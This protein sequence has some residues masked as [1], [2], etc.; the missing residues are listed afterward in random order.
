MGRFLRDISIDN[1]ILF[2]SENMIFSNVSYDITDD[3]SSMIYKLQKVN[4][5]KEIETEKDRECEY[6]L[7][8]KK[9][10]YSR[11]HSTDWRS[12][13]HIEYKN[14]ILDEYSKYINGSKYED[15]IHK[16]K[17]EINFIYQ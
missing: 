1:F 4:I 15:N 14:L 9:V 7:C 2:C 13:V 11:R 10:M 16:F 6:K 12:R 3:L 5:V 17:G 8:N